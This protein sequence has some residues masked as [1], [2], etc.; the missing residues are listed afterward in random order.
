MQCI[1]YDMEPQT[2]TIELDPSAAAV[3]RALQEKAE[4]QG[5]TLYEIL[6][7]LA[8]EWNG[9]EI[10]TPNLTT[11]QKAD[12]VVQWLR[13]HSVKGVIADDS[14]ESIY[15]REDEAL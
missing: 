13:S 8:E 14:R 1:L 10:A 2:V 4:A 12:D 11:A 9:T 5:L 15:T 3:L 6:R 7:P